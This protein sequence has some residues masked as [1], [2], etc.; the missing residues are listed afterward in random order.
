MFK[1]RRPTLI[2]LEVLTVAVFL[3]TSIMVPVGP[4]LRVTQADPSPG[5]GQSFT[6]LQPGFTEEIFGVSS[7]FAGGVAF[8]PDGDPL[9]DN[10][11]GSGSPL[12]RYDR[13]SVA[14]IV[15]G[16]SLHPETILSS[17]A[18]CGLTNHPDGNLYTNTSLG[19]IRLNAD[20]GAQIGSP[21]GPAGNALGITPDPQTGNL[22]YVGS[23]GTIRFVNPTFT[24]SGVF[25]AVTTG[26]FVDGIFFDP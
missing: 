23:D 14:P 12:H 6:F 22:V 4:H 15:H 19:V 24:T 13:Q 8:A 7:N 20:T 3:L 17:N 5:P 25:S 11:A 10:C 18:G 16:T 9:M 21:F 1:I 2:K 26:N